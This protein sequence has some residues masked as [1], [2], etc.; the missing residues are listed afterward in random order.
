MAAVVS[1]TQ[2]PSLA[3]QPSFNFHHD[4]LTIL[5]ATVLIVAGSKLWL[6]IFETT[7]D[8]ILSDIFLSF[9]SSRNWLWANTHHLRPTLPRQPMTGHSGVE[10]VHL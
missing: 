5:M 2:H 1:S 10:R 9:L 3:L 4:S 7:A 6:R 8:F